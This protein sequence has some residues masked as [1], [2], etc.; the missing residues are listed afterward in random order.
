MCSPSARGPRPR[1][2]FTT[3]CTF[4]PAMRSTASTT[5]GCESP[6]F[7]TT[8]DTTIPPLDANEP[9]RAKYLEPH[10]HWG[11]D[12]TLTALDFSVPIRIRPIRVRLG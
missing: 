12:F 11:L 5:P 4:P 8:V 6:T 7:A 2:V 1:G 10:E 9:Y 3:S